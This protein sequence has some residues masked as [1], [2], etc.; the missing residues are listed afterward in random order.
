MTASVFFNLLSSRILFILSTLAASSSP[1]DLLT[2]RK[3][4][5]FLLRSSGCQTCHKINLPFY[6]RSFVK[7]I[8]S[9]KQKVIFTSLSGIEIADITSQEIL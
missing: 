8:E 5:F 9:F 3:F 6:S 4:F 1:Q 7:I 2:I